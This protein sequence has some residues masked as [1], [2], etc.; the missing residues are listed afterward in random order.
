MMPRV[1]SIRYLLV[2]ARARWRLVL[3]LLGGAFVRVWLTVLLLLTLI[4]ILLIIIISILSLLFMIITLPSVILLIWSAESSLQVKIMSLALTFYS[5]DFPSIRHL[6]GVIILWRLSQISS[7][8]CLGVWKIP[9]LPIL[10]SWSLF[11][12]VASIIR[13]ILLWIY[14]IM[15]C[16]FH[17]PILLGLRLSLPVH[18]FR[19]LLYILWIAL[20]NACWISR[21][22]DLLSLV[23]L[24][25]ILL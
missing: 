7:R 20:I 4:L 17:L 6:W 12:R 3:A 1:F 16:V 15:L 25:L 24:L 2:V 9:C 10:H 19:P 18:V 22:R 13:V 21:G 8:L 23:P 14:F 5:S 11:L